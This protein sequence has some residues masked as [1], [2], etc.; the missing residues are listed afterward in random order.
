MVWACF[1]INA[2]EYGC[3]T[4]PYGCLQLCV[5]R[6]CHFILSLLYYRTLT[7]SGA[8]KNKKIDVNLD[9]LYVLPCALTRASTHR[10]AH[11]SHIMHMHHTPCTCITHQAHASYPTPAKQSQK[12]QSVFL[13]RN[14]RGRGQI[15]NIPSRFRGKR[16]VQQIE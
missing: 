7:S 1:L 16:G 10:H 12:C 15:Q 6:L 4:A 9:D 11:V 13:F 8:K 2:W 14:S 5:M 3:A